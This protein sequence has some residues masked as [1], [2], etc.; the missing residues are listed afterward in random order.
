MAAKYI[1][2]AER[3]ETYCAPHRPGR[4][5]FSQCGRKWR[6]ELNGKKLCGPHFRER[7]SST[8]DAV[9]KHD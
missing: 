7:R 2:S 4:M 8:S 5:G 6:F 1:P 3:C 9:V